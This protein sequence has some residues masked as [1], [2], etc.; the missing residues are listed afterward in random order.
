MAEAQQKDNRKDSNDFY[1]IR[2]KLSKFEKSVRRNSLKD[3][4]ER[5]GIKDKKK[6]KEIEEFF[7]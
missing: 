5:Y 1:E 6:L 2:A 3:Y 4:A 7:L